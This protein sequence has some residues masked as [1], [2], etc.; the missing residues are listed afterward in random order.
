MSQTSAEKRNAWNKKNY[1]QVS[2]QIRPEEK[3]LWMAGAQRR[4]ISLTEYIRRAIR[5][6]DP[7]DAQLDYFDCLSPKGKN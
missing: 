2:M 1:V 4:G 3:E 6:F 5:E 7:D